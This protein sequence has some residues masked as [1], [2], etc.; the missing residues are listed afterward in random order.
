MSLFRRKQHRADRDNGVNERLRPPHPEEEA[1]MFPSY[2]G[3]ELRADDGKRTP[4]HGG[5]PVWGSLDHTVESGSTNWRAIA[6]SFQGVAEEY[7]LKPERVEGLHAGDLRRL[8][9]QNGALQE[10]LANAETRA[11]L[12]ERAAAGFLGAADALISVPPPVRGAIEPLGQSDQAIQK[13]EAR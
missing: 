9:G 5:G 4:P 2:D 12:Y 11:D 13:E 1:A 3:S 8:R 6:V 10:R 7:R